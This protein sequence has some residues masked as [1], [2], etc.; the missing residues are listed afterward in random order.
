MKMDKNI[1]GEFKKGN[2]E[3]TSHIYNRH[4]Q[5]LYRY[6]KKITS[7]SELIKDTIQELFL[8]L[9]R[10]RHNLSELDNIQFYLIKAFRRRI[11]AELKKNTLVEKIEDRTSSSELT[12]T[13]SYE[14]ELIRKE[15]LTHREKLVQKGLKALTPKQREILFYRFTCNF[16]YSQIC[17]L[18]SLKY[19]SARKMTFRALQSLKQCLSKTDFNF[20]VLHLQLFA[21]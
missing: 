21:I 18:M 17:E 8:D 12:I 10:T 2:S 1:W 11:L 13:Y 7:D 14:E 6:G 16:D 9:I 15:H 5:I 3:A 20:F 4:V 19:D